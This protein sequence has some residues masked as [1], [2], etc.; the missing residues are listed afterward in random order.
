MRAMAIALAVLASPGVARAQWTDHARVSINAGIQQPASTT[1][2][3]TTTKS[4][5]LETASINTTYDVPKSQFFDGGVLVRVKG[6]FGVGVAVSSFSKSSVATISGSI[7][8]PF[9]FNTPRTLTGSATSLERSETG[10]HIQAAYVVSSKHVDVAIS[11]GPTLFN[12]SQDLVADVAYADVYPYDSVTFTSAT[13]SKASATKLGF[14]VGADVGVKFS[15]NIGVGGL[16]RFSR[17]TVNVP[18]TGTAAG[19]SADVGGLQAGGGVR[20][21]F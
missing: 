4:V 16:I 9:F 3:S 10:V 18:L 7:P 20:L 2:T 8:H 12:V 17:A 1:F 14:N 21:Y 11:G 13:I 19:V 15:K 6:G 5:F